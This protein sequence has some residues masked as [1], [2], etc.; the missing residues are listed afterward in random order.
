MP[1]TMS[2]PALSSSSTLP[3][4]A[5][6]DPYIFLGV[7]DVKNKGLGLL[8][9]SCNSLSA[10]EPESLIWESIKPIFLQ[11][12]TCRSSSL[13]SRM[14]FNSLF[15]VYYPVSNMNRIHLLQ[16]LSILKHLPV[17]GIQLEWASAF[18]RAGCGGQTEQDSRIT[19]VLHSSGEGG[20]GLESW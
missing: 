5:H 4:A 7:M 18:H 16:K 1:A 2:L 6:S 12:E 13:S 15:P 8:S 3:G 17:S 19:H 20:G 11:A 14:A 10:K 9:R